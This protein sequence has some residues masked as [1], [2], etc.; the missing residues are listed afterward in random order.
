MRE[1]MITEGLNH[2]KAAD[3]LKAYPGPGEPSTIVTI[4]EPA[5]DLPGGFEEIS[6][7]SATTPPGIPDDRMVTDF[8]AAMLIE[9][10]GAVQFVTGVSGSV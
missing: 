8:P 6:G 2:A 9:V 4:A 7:E 1:E 5:D 10:V 3:T